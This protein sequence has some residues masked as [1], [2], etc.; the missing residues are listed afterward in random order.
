MEVTLNLYGIIKV[1]SIISILSIIA[2]LVHNGFIFKSFSKH[3]S[4]LFDKFLSKYPDVAPEFMKK[5][6]K[7]QN[8]E[9]NQEIHEVNKRLDEQ[10]K[11][12]NELGQAIQKIVIIL[13][14]KKN[15]EL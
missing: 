11:K 12:I 15:K 2:F 7:E 4:G 14:E 1:L 8:I 5:G 6:I 3:D 10:D 9:N 13:E